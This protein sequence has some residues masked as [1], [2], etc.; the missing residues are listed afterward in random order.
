M[1]GRSKMLREENVEILCGEVEKYPSLTLQQLAQR[2]QESCGI[3]ILK[4]TVHNCL[5]A[6]LITFKKAHAMPATINTPA[7]KELQ[8][9]YVEQLT[10]CMPASNNMDG[11]KQP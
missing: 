2:L 3:S 9:Q 1:N 5:E 6:C 10:S 7:K 4:S 11:C 8:C